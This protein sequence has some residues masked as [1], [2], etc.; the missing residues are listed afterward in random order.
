MH[1]SLPLSKEEHGK[2]F[3][4]GVGEFG[5]LGDSDSNTG[6]LP[7]LFRFFFFCLFPRHPFYIYTASRRK[8][9]TCKKIKV[10]I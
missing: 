10:G 2:E 3:K 7:N 1:F 4:G 5:A 9:T 8:A 6:V